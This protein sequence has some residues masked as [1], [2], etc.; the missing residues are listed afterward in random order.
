[1]GFISLLHFN[2]VLKEH[3]YHNVFKVI[4]F[5]LQIYDH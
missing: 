1:M 4:D 2:M 3:G 5:L